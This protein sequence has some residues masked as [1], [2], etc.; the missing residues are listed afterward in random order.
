MNPRVISV[1][2]IPIT[3]PLHCDVLKRAVK[4]TFLSAAGVEFKLVSPATILAQVSWSS[5]VN[6]RT[7]VLVV[8]GLPA[9]TLGARVEL[10]VLLLFCAVTNGSKGL[11]GQ[12]GGMRRPKT[13]Q[14]RQARGCDNC[15][16]LACQ[17]N[18]LA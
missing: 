7:R 9:S 12:D 16:R 8:S 15:C 3:V 1:S 17:H 2:C 11:S 4:L 10:E 5:A 13:P 14:W 6:F 18:S